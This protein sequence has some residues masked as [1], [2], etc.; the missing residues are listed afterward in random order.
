MDWIVRYIKTTFTFFL[1][2]TDSVGRKGKLVFAVI[3]KQEVAY[4]RRC[5]SG[6]YRRSKQ[7]DTVPQVLFI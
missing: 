6:N 5:F 4:L 2:A 3:Q 1:H 7:R